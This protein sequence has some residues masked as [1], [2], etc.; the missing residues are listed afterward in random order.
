MAYLGIT[1]HLVV[2]LGAICFALCV[3]HQ[4]TSSTADQVVTSSRMNYDA[5]CNDSTLRSSNSTKCCY[6][7]D[8]RNT[9]VQCV[10]LSNDKMNETLNGLIKHEYHQFVR[11]LTFM[12]NNTWIG[13]YPT[14]EV[15]SLKL[16]KLREFSKLE[17]SIL[18]L[19]LFQPS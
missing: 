3:D 4:D 6:C 17:N 14:I 10:L 8:S 1:Y 9:S 5:S 16:S 7:S 18:R 2:I 13:K 11:E 12:I 19:Q 15:H